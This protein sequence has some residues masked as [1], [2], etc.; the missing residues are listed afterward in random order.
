MEAEAV[1][2]EHALER[3][4]SFSSA[5]ALKANVVSLGA[6]FSTTD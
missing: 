4:E 6:N 1:C 3:V 2:K 5:E